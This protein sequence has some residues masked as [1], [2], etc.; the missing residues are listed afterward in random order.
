M[1]GTQETATSA[2][3]NRLYGGEK[4]R[5]KR[6]FRKTHPTV[7]FHCGTAETGIVIKT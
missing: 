7:T 4:L 6:Y 1:S 3:L 2:A 5:I